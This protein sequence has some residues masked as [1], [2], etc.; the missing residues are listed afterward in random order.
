MNRPL[1]PEGWTLTYES[2][3]E[4]DGRDGLCVE[5]DDGDVT[6]SWTEGCDDHFGTT[7]RSARFPLAV[8]LALA[9]GAL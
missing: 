1:L 7:T 3:A 2:A 5:V 6:V 9:G 8:V 4:R